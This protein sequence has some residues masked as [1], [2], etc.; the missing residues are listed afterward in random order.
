MRLARG[1]Q[2]AVAGWNV[3]RGV[4]CALG[5]WS[6]EFRAVVP[7]VGLLA[8]VKSHL[9][10][11]AGY[12]FGGYLHRLEHEGTRVDRYHNRRALDFAVASVVSGAAT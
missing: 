12:H 9:V 3:M 11:I 8:I 5:R 6:S 2:I 4:P 10:Q 7:A 1:F